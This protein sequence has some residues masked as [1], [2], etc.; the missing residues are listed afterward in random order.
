MCTGSILNPPALLPF[1]LGLA[2]SFASSPSSSSPSPP[3]SSPPIPHPHLVSSASCYNPPKL[4]PSAETNPQ[5][6]LTMSPARCELVRLPSMHT[7]VYAHPL[8]PASVIDPRTEFSR[9]QL[10]LW[11]ILTLVS[12]LLV[13]LTSIYYNF[14]RPTEGKYHRHTIWGQNVSQDSPLCFPADIVLTPDPESTTHSILPQSHHWQHLLGCAV[15]HPDPLPVQS[16]RPRR[17]HQ[18]RCPACPC[19]RLQQPSWLRLHSPV[20]PLLLLVG[21]VARC[22]QLVQPDLHLFPLPQEP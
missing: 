4:Q 9:S 19:I 21:S 8:T 12:Y 18:S 3:P 10:V 15:H 17:A 5:S 20:V 6:C 11:R 14:R 16:L 2:T 7:V 13:V 22:S 1:F